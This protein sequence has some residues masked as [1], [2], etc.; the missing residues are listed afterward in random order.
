MWCSALWWMHC[1]IHC[2]VASLRRPHYTPKLTFLIDMYEKQ[3]SALQMLSKVCFLCTNPRVCGCR[4]TKHPTSI[5]PNVPPPPFLS[6][7]HPSLPPCI[8]P[9]TRAQFSHT[10]V[11]IKAQRVWQS[12]CI[13]GGGYIENPGT[14]YLESPVRTRHI[15]QP[16]KGL[17]GPQFSIHASFQRRYLQTF[18][19][20]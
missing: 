13:E 15:C 2:Y 4:T 17:R 8:C 19:F 18:F 10:P 20:K 7:F 16:Q 14:K 3:A 12:V 5:G 6:E 1:R 9:P 11:R